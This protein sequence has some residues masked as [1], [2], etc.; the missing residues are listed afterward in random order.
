MDYKD[1]V[2]CVEWEIERVI[3][4]TKEKSKLK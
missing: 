2:V 1:E 3:H 4:N